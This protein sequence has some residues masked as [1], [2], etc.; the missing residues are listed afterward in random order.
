MANVDQS[1]NNLFYDSL[2]TMNKINEG[3]F[4]NVRFQQK[5][6]MIW[7]WISTL[8]ISLGGII[9]AFRKK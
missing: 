3:E 5:S 2:I 7:I 4:F 1:K 6:M 9:S 8:F